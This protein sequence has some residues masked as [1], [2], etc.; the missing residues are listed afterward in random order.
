MEES[1][2]VVT[3]AFGY[4]GRYIAKHLLD[5]GKNV[6][7]ITTHPHKPNPFKEV[8]PAYPYNFNDLEKLISS[9]RGANTLYNTYWV[10]F[11]YG[12]VNFDQA[13]DNT[14]ILFDAAR[15]AGVKKIIHI[16]VTNASVDS[17]LPYYRG[18]AMQEKLLMESGLPY[19]IV[20]P[21]L[22]FGKEDIL[23]NNIAWLLRKFPLFPIFGSGDYQVQPVFVGDLAEIAISSSHSTISQTIDAIGPE[24]LSFNEMVQFIRNTLGSKCHLIHLPAWLAVSLGKLVGIAVRDVVLTQDEAKGL[25]DNM[26]TSSQIPNG[27]TRFS[28]W[29]SSNIDTLG[30]AYSSELERHFRYPSK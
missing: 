3:G 27:K 8:I 19:A 9:L 14:R 25:M 26:L 21:T 13:V 18:K 28:E 16:S 10:R 22:V 12:N 11:N 29:V 15:Q 1:F 30:Q 7:T 4:I 5:S 24:T 6:R 20:R 17:S 2:E 23:V